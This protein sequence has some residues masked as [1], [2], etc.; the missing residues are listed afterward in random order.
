MKRS[1]L[2]PA[3]L[4]LCLCAS[5][6]E[7]YSQDGERQCAP[8][9]IF[10]EGVISRPGNNWE[11]RLSLSPD[12]NLALWTVGNSFAGEKLVV[13]MSEYRRGGWGE[14]VVAPFS[15]IYDD[16]DTIFAPDGKT[17]YFSSKRPLQSGG[18]PLQTF[19]LWKVRYSDSRGWGQPEH[20]GAGPNSAADEL[21]P[22]IDRHGNLY[23]GSN[24]DNESW[25]VWHSPRLPNGRF[26]PAVKLSSAV[27]TTEY[28]EYN[29]EISPDGKTLL[30]ASLS[31]PGGY[32]WG[33][34]YRSDVRHGAFRPA[35]NL[36]PCINSA[37]DDYHPTMLWDENKLIW[38][39]N[40]I[41]DPDWYPDFFITKFRLDD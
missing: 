1:T 8:L 22:S 27:N 14:P 10:G 13:L 18:Q 28:W 17:V 31:R 7:A 33:D 24:R 21:Y 4:A 35:Q 11:S 3:A 39:R 9:K 38:V 29:P 15:G 23:Y 25:D 34:I 41:E 36:G 26:G 2:L 12:R 6:F 16:V 30:F 20:L 19:D 5:A 37:A 40:F 32:G